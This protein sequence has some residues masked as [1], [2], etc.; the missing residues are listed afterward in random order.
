MTSSDYVAWNQAVRESSR[1]SPNCIPEYLDALCKVAGGIFRLLAVCDDTPTHSCIALYIRGNGRDRYVSGRNLLY[2]N[3]PLVR[4]L[5]NATPVT[6]SVCATS[7]ESNESY[8]TNAFLRWHVVQELS[9]DGYTTNG[10]TD[11]RQPDVARFKSQLGGELVLS[12]ALSRPASVWDHLQQAGQLIK[13]G[14]RSHL[15]RTIRWHDN[16]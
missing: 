16:K 3:G 11:A 14:S 10:P 2:Y 9:D 13:Q 5:P 7:I 15:K 12:I 8:G 4:E 1:G 6:H